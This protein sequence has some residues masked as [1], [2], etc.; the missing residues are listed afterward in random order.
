MSAAVWRIPPSTTQ[1]FA[2]VPADAPVAVL[3]RHSVRGPLPPGNAGD[4]VPLTCAGVGLARHLGAMLG[5]RLSSLHAGP[6]R[7]C[8]ET[9]EALRSGAG[10]DVPVF[11][12][13]LLGDPSVFVA[14]TRLAWSN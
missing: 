1:W 8:M 2:D 12:D 5:D 13:S 11:A 7:R 9:A 6:L 4:A 10:V 14:D 3:L